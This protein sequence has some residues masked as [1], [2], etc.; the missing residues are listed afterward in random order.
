MLMI[1]IEKFWL[2]EV[3]RYYVMKDYGVKLK[4][5]DFYLRVLRKCGI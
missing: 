3:N 4:S 5:L 1:E 2:E